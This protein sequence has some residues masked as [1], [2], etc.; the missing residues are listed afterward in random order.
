MQWSHQFRVP[1]LPS[2]RTTP[3]P[4]RPRAPALRQ[5]QPPQREARASDAGAPRKRRRSAATDS[6]PHSAQPEKSAVVVKQEDSAQPHT[7]N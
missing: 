6:G 4:V 2:L 1:P 5:K 7:A 3:E